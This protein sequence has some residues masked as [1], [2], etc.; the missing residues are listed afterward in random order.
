MPMICNGQRPINEYS[1]IKTDW[2]VN[3]KTQELILH[4]TCK[5]KVRFEICTTCKESKN[6]R[7]GAAG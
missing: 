5:Y 6:L 3:I 7:Y 4:G 1:D 2:N